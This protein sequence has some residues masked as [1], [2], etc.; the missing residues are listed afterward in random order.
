[1]SGCACPTPTAAPGTQAELNVTRDLGRWQDRHWEA[2]PAD[3]AD[4]RIT[5]VLPEGTRVYYLNLF[6]DRGC[7]VSTEHETLE[8]AP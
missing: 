3:C 6:D 2:L 7:V 1:V 5:A 8:P 4:G